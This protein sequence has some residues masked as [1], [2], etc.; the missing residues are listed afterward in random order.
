MTP[1]HATRLAELLSPRVALA[2]LLVLA[3]PAHAAD[4]P[5]VTTSGGVVAAD[6]E[7]ASAAGARVLAVGVPGE[8]AGLAHLVA[9]W[10]TRSWRRALGPA[11]RLA[12]DGFVVSRFLAR[13]TGRVVEDLP[14]Q[15]RFAGVRALIVGAGA[16][17]AEGETIT[18]PALA[19]TLA[20]LAADGAGAFYRG[21]L[22]DDLIAT[23]TAGGGVMTAA[24]LAG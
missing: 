14:D 4:P 12:R 20:T 7:A 11:I 6:H 21:P 23:V 5:P 2:V 22:A 8:P 1:E 16:G 15:P 13:A 9:T 24:D 17:L 10:G 18:R 19:V 3:G